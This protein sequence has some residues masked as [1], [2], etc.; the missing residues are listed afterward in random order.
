MKA[1]HAVN[2]ETHKI[3]ARE[4]PESTAGSLGEGSNNY[5]KGTL[6]PM[7]STEKQKTIALTRKHVETKT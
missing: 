4:P 3:K 2:E 5:N 1:E 7:M 6:Q